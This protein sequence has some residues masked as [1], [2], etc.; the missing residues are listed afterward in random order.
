MIEIKNLKKQYGER[1]VLDIPYLKIKKGE[2]VIL[3]GHNGSGKST[4][5]KILGGIISDFEGQVN[6]TGEVYYMPQQCVPFNKS[7]R[8]NIIYS[9]KKNENK[10]EICDE[11]LEKL[12]LK[13]LENKNAK[14]LS[15]GECQRLCLGRVIANKGEILILDE[16]ASAADSE[17]TRL[18]EKVIENY[19]KETGCTLIITTHS[20]S[21][22]ERLKGRPIE[23]LDGKQVEKN[24]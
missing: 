15:G 21:Q 4:L 16:P 23:L 11:I 24:A 17:S 19:Q 5:L 9:L 3:T 1:T 12:N 18:I 7:V 6:I 20:K 8:K 22:A 10:N 13:A 2:R 14:T